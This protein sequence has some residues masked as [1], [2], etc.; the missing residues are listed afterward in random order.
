MIIQ[1]NITTEMRQRLAFAETLSVD[2][3]A[4]PEIA[5]LKADLV[6]AHAHIEHLHG[7][8]K[9]YNLTRKIAEVVSAW[10]ESQCQL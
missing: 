6:A 7:L 5:E 8:V 1:M 3:S 10:E 2:I 4:H 9:K